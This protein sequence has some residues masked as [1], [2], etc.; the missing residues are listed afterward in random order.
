MLFTHDHL[1]HFSGSATEAI[2]KATAAPIV[3]E[4]KVTKKLNGKIP[5]E[6]LT[7]A[8]TR[9]TYNFDDHPPQLL[10]EFIVVQ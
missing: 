6:K 1:D 8:E 5:A 3:A 7:S 10:R 9:K 4:A 2:F